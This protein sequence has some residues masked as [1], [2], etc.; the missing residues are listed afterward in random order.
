VINGYH[1]ISYDQSANPGHVFDYIVD[2]QYNG[3]GDNWIDEMNDLANW[4]WEPADQCATSVVLGDASAS[5][6]NQFYNGGFRDLKST[7]AHSGSSFFY[8][9]GCDPDD[10]EKL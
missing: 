3:I 7:G 6:A 4:A 10:G 1:G 5:R 8:I 2:S 9:D